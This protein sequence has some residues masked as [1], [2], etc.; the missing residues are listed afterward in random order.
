[1]I[2]VT[3]PASPSSPSI[4]LIAL[5]TPT[6]QRSETSVPHAP[7][8][9]SPRNGTLNASK[10]QPTRTRSQAARNCTRNFLAGE[11]P[12]RS[13]T[14]PTRKTRLTAI[15]R[16]TS[17]G[18]GMRIAHSFQ[19]AIRPRS[20][21]AER[22]ATIAT[23]PSRGTAVACTFFLSPDS[24]GRSSERRISAR[25]TTGGTR[26]LATVPARSAA[27]EPAMSSGSM[28]K[29]KDAIAASDRRRCVPRHRPPRW[30]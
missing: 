2:A 11:T 29:W 16:V 12:K 3:P 28:S 14:S 21:P 27:A 25:R 22:P 4:R 23:P 5:V 15:G 19:P 1:M 9:I 24:V 13:S 17:S 18:R 7:K 10:L 6:T 20:A 26:R 8:W 30:P